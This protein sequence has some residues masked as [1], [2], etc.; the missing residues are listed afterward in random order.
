MMYESKLQI[1]IISTLSLYK[2]ARENKKNHYFMFNLKTSMSKNNKKKIQIHNMF[3]DN[4]TY[5]AQSC[6]QRSSKLEISMI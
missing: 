3:D 2:Q 6:F 4:I 5:L 1:C